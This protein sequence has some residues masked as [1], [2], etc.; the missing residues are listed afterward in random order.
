[1]TWIQLLTEEPELQ[2]VVQGLAPAGAT[3][4]ATGLREPRGGTPPAAVVVAASGTRV[5]FIERSLADAEARGLKMRTIVL[6]PFSRELAT[7]LVRAL[8]PH[9]V[10]LDDVRQELGPLLAQMVASDLR[11]LVSAALLER[12][13]PDP[14]LRKAVEQAF[15]GA[16]CPTTVSALAARAHCTPSTLRAHWRRSALPDS[17]Q[18]LVEWAILAALAE[19]RGDGSKLSTVSRLIGLHETT[20]Y[21][22]SRRRL[23][24]SPSLVSRTALL[25]ALEE[26]LP[27]AA[28]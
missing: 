27:A 1:M 7:A 22:A 16:E 25:S 9:V 3:V 6:A 18:A 2:G 15:V 19:L 20:L 8:C 26:W 21:R 24:L 10:W 5:P 17:P 11:F 13:G 4:R 12:C 14:I 28:G 23:G